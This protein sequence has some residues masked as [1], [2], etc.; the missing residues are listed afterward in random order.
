M[1]RLTIFCDLVLTASDASLLEKGAFPHKVV[2]AQLPASS[3]LV[4]TGSDSAI[5]TADVVFGQPATESVAS[6]GR[7][8]W[9][10][11]TSA[12]YT[13]Y[14]SRL[15]R[16]LLERC[17]IALTT[18]SAV[19]AESCVEQ[20][21]AYILCQVRQLPRSL[22]MQLKIGSSE[23]YETSASCKLL[24]EQ[25]ACLI[26][27]GGIGSLFARMVVPFGLELTVIRR[28]RRGDEGLP[29][30]APEAYAE[31]FIGADHIVSS[32]P[33]SDSTREYINATRIS[34]MKTGVAFYNVGRGPTVDQ[35]ALLA[36]LQNGQISAAWLDVTVPEPLP[37]EHPL[38]ALP[39]CHITPH[40]AGGHLHE[41]QRLIR[42]F[43][44]NLRCFLN[45]QPMINR[46]MQD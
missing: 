23:W 9:I 27:F 12:G 14:D 36:S 15:F 31:A 34:A 19:F 20:L 24:S 42:H 1:E 38:R 3:M 13:R 8:R 43:L 28:K 11:L 2:F 26:G 32:L 33:E 21:M 39:N 17:N 45:G 25:R 44:K 4:A 30:F 40:L 16:G 6:A 46:V 5:A 41:P 22:G 35:T 10:H 29:V 18:S 37:A 7:L